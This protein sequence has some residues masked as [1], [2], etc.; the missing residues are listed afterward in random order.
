MTNIVEFKN[1]NIKI[2]WK[3][4][5]KDITFSIKKWELLGYLWANWSWKSTTLKVMS[6]LLKPSS[7]IYKFNWEEFS[8]NN[9]NDIWAIIN[10]PRLYDNLNAYDNMRIFSNLEWKK[11]NKKDFDE[12][13]DLVWLYKDS[14]E[15]KVWTYST[16]MLNM[17]IIA[18]SLLWDP[19]LLIYDEITSGLDIEAKERIRILLTDLKNKWYSI[20]FSSHELDQIQKVS[21]KIV[22][23]SDKR[24]KFEWTLK[25]MEKHWDDIEQSYLNLIK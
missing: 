24:I 17:L 4:I 20:I 5:L 25:E 1:I 21:D 12:L 10:H 22:I 18:I 8:L 2:W 6:W 3:E 19:K 14:R 15:Q 9:L 23:I 11:K 7:W 16:G 13:L